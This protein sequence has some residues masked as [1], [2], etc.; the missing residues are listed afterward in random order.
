MATISTKVADVSTIAGDVLTGSG[1]AEKVELATPEEVAPT[2]VV[3]AEISVAVLV[4]VVVEGDSCKVEGVGGWLDEG[5]RDAEGLR[6][7]E[8]VLDGAVEKSV[9][10]EVVMDASVVVAL[11]VAAAPSS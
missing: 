2:D 9:E 6:T 11:V 8:D 7:M 5:E 4:N 1:S 10:A 3:A